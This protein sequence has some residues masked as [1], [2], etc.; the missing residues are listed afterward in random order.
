MI[1]KIH[2]DSVFSKI[3]GLV[4]WEKSPDNCFVSFPF[5]HH[6]IC[7]SRVLERTWA[8]YSQGFYEEAYRKKSRAAFDR[9][10]SLELVVFMAVGGD[11]LF[12]P[13]YKSR[14]QSGSEI[15]RNRPLRKVSH[16]NIICLAV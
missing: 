4:V 8:L 14:S 6:K 11:A 1:N 5:C 16:L 13:R 12:G 3:F 9:S 7:S 2:F 10:P 15:L